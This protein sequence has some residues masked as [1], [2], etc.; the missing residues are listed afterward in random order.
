MPQL[1]GPLPTK[2]LS[3]TVVSKDLGFPM[4]LL[5]TTPA[6][7]VLECKYLSSS[8]PQ[9]ALIVRMSNIKADQAS[10]SYGRITNNYAVTLKSKGEDAGVG[11]ESRIFQTRP[12]N[13]AL[14][15]HDAD[16][17]TVIMTFI[18]P[19]ANKLRAQVPPSRHRR[20]EEVLSRRQAPSRGSGERA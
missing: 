5:S 7:G 17:T 13:A 9:R 3:A 12:F 11:T 20:H 15:A 14:V 8:K 19:G 18:S 10:G 16:G 6:N 4:T 1:S 2:C